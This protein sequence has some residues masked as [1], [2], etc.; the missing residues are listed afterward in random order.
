MVKMKKFGLIAL[1]AILISACGSEEKTAQENKDSEI[2][3]VTKIVDLNDRFTKIFVEKY[4]REQLTLIQD[5]IKM[6]LDLLKKDFP[7]SDTLPS[8]LFLAGEAAMKVSKGDDAIAYFSELVENHP[9]HDQVDK[10]MYFIGYT[11]EVVLQNIEKAK[12]A[13]KKLA[14]EKPNSDWGENARSQVLYINSKSPTQ[15]AMNDEAVIDTAD[16]K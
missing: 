3:V 9:D 14:R 13:Y 1:L 6:E 12:E 8:M 7:T 16:Q 5:S 2:L 4:N 11:Y 10:A 15:D